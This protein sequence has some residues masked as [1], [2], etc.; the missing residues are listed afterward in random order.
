M[1]LLGLIGGHKPIHPKHQQES[2][3]GT[4]EML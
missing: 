4:V 2:V 3:T 1:P